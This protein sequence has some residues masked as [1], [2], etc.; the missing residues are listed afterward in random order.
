MNWSLIQEILRPEIYILIGIV[1]SLICSIFSS[2][3]RH[4][5]LVAAISSLLASMHLVFKHLPSVMDGSIAYEG[6]NSILFNSFVSD[7]LSIFLRALIYFVTFLICLASSKYL[8]VLESPGE[9]YPILLT[10]SLGGGLLTGA[11]DFLSMFVAL[12]TLGLSAILMASYARL[13]QGSNEAGI[14]YLLSS[15]FATTILLFGISLM[16]GL[17]GATNFA[18]FAGKIQSLL[19]VGVVSPAVQVLVA[20]LIVGAMSFKLAA[21][22]F[23]NWSPDVYDGAPTCTTLFLSVVSK[24]A[25]IAIAMRLFLVVF[26]GAGLI[27]FFLFAIAILSITIGNYIGVVEVINR[28]STKRLLAYSSIA[29]AGYM[30]IG[31]AVLQR[32]SLSALILYLTVYAFMNTGAFISLISFEQ[33]SHSEK[34]YDLAGLIKRRPVLAICFALC[35]INLAGLPFIPAGFIAKFYLFSSAYASQ[36][37]FGP[38]LAIVGLLG[39]LVGL[40]YYLYLVKIMIVDEPSDAVKDLPSEDENSNVKPI[41]IGLATSLILMTIAGITHTGFF[42]TLANNVV[43]SIG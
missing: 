3:K 10:A 28:A 7:G 15:A 39:S 14:K 21:V 36:V 20:A 32:E 25:A 22:P 35:L 11:N 4:V 38:L 8:Q 18:A 23:H 31:L 13:N 30:I 41:W 42:V 19:S 5:W 40:Y 2:S 1:L 37:Y 43:S 34:I 6:S 24:T 12:E 16:Y 9:Y 26:G 27:S 17:T 29:Q 33:E